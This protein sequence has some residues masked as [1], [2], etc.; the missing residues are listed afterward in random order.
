MSLGQRHKWPLCLGDM[1]KQW[2]LNGDAA[3]RSITAVIDRLSMAR[4]KKAPDNF[5][6]SFCLSGIWSRRENTV[7]TRNMMSNCP[8]KVI[9]QQNK[10]AAPSSGDIVLGS[11]FDSGL[12]HAWWS[13]VV[14][15]H[16]W[17]K[18]K[19]KKEPKGKKRENE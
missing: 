8:C 9:A 15:G 2:P 11:W 1:K 3:S 19:E 6:T 10:T 16:T 5:L 18:E 4:V 17:Q 12:A 14:T 13:L 7:L